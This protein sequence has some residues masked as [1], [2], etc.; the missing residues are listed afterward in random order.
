MNNVYTKLK[1]NFIEDD[2]LEWFINL[3]KSIQCYNKIVNVLQKP[4]KL[5]LFYGKPGSGKTFLLNKILKD[6]D[7]ENIIY[8]SHPFFNESDFLNEVCEKLKISI[9]SKNFEA[10]L[11]EYDLSL[12]GVDEILKNQKI[13]IL[14][15][16][17]LYP[18]KLIEKIRLMAD[19]RYFKVL[20]TVHKTSD[21]D[22][23]AK[24]YFSTRIW[25]SIELKSADL[26]EIRVYIQK[27]LDDKINLINFSQ[28]D[29]ALIHN[30]CKGN[31]RTLN[32]LMY[33]FL[34]IC[35][36][37]EAHKPSMLSTSKNNKKLIYMAAID[38]ELINA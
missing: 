21:E 33:K 36:S 31:L 6:L 22:V 1:N 15:E 13:I 19:S 12:K 26:A 11:K 17:Q 28:N 23:L 7:N 2:N 37:Y 10:F 25:E 4:I 35:E 3:D 14:D 24:D 32:K 29:Y 38:T 34:Q 30:L 8:F 5:A 20:F 9:S 16:A 27:K 18:P